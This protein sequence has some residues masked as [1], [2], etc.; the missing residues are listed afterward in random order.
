MVQA[1]PYINGKTIVKAREDKLAQW[2][3]EHIISIDGNEH[4]GVDPNGCTKF[5]KYN[6]SSSSFAHHMR[7]TSSEQLVPI[8][9]FNTVYAE[10]KIEHLSQPENTNSRHN[11]MDSLVLLCCKD[12]LCVYPLKSVVQIF[13][14]H[15]TGESNLFNVDIKVEFQG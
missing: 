4:Y 3:K 5:T 8:N 7:S 1:D 15:R 2:F 11:T 9:M 13:V 14:R 6:G 10:P 12:A